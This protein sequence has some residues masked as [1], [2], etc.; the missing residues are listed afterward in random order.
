VRST[1]GFPLRS[2]TFTART[3]RSV[4]IAVALIAAP[5]HAQQAAPAPAPA[6]PAT[7]APAPAPAVE[8]TPAPSAPAPPAESSIEEQLR[9]MKA[10]IDAQAAE[11]AQ[12]RAASDE[13][14]VEAELAAIGGEGD[15]E[16]FARPDTL[17]IYGYLDVGL[18]RLF[19]RKDNN[20]R[21]FSTT[22]AS[23]FLLGNVNFYFD[24]SPATDW[25]GLTEIRFTNLPHGDD[26][27]GVQGLL[28]YERIDTTANNQTSPDGRDKVLLGSII[29]ER[30]WIQWQR[31]PQLNVRVGQWLTPFGIWNVDHGTPVLITLL[32]PD[33]QISQQFPSRQTGLLFEGAVPIDAWTLRYDAYISNGRTKSLFDYTD[34]KALGARLVLAKLGGDMIGFG[35][36]FYYGTS[37]DQQK[38][39]VDFSPLRI[40]RENKVELTEVAA[41][42]DFALDLGPLRLRSEGVMRHVEYEEGKF[43]P[44][45]NDQPNAFEPSHYY[46]EGYLLGGYRLP[47]LGLEPTMWLELIYSPSPSGNL[48]ATIG[49]GLNVHFDPSVQLKN[50]VGYVRF[51]DRPD[52]S[53][54]VYMWTAQTRLVL[55]F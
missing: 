7:P 13:H 25:R 35:T 5:A 52:G 6:A 8:P 41:G 24:V 39:I 44:P 23:T 53:R 3:F 36:S 50:V 54:D 9:A 28:P 40:E 48:A 47:W 43:A 1:S 33:F 17:S 16:E 30:A 18:V 11:I 46:W 4:L 19:A 55:A 12:L 51:M 2:N 15:V 22:E 29:I 21:G 14:A 49:P 37:Q 26:V 34:D 32:Q 38:N 31:Y 27:P 45:E 10:Q 20:I 42:V